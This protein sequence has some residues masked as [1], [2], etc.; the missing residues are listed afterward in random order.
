M[1]KNSTPDA[2][3]ADR[4]A[5]PD[6]P[7]PGA[8]ASADPGPVPHAD[9]ATPPRPGDDNTAPSLVW[10]PV[11]DELNGW[12]VVHFQSS[13][14]TVIE[15]MKFTPPA[16]PAASG[17]PTP[18]VPPYAPPAPIDD[19]AG[20]TTLLPLESDFDLPE[21][22]LIEP[23]S[24]QPPASAARV[25]DEDDARP[26]APDDRTVVIPRPAAFA[27]PHRP[28]PA[29]VPGVPESPRVSSQE[30]T[31]PG[32]ATRILVGPAFAASVGH[33]PTVPV[34]ALHRAERPQPAFGPRHPMEETLPAGVTREMLAR[35]SDGDTAT[36]HADDTVTRFIA[37]GD[38]HPSSVPAARRAPAGPAG[39]P[40]PFSRV[41]SRGPQP[42]VDG[43]AAPEP[44]PISLAPPPLAFGPRVPAPSAPAAAPPSIATAPTGPLSIAAAGLRDP[45]IPTRPAPTSTRSKLLSMAGALV[46]VLLLALGAYQV[47]SMRSTAAAGP[48]MA[49]LSVESSPAGATVVVD[50][51]PRGT[52]P[53]RLELAEGN[54]AL[55]VSHAGA[56]RRVPLTLAAGTITAHSFEFA[57]PPP[58]VVA[59]AAIEIRSEPAGGRVLVDGVP[60]GTTPIVVTG[61]TAGRHEVQVGGPF[62]TVT[63]TVTLAAKQQA[64]LV[65][66]PARPAATAEAGSARSPRAAAGTGFIAIESPIVLRVV[67]NGDFVGTS[68]DARLQL[69]VGPQVIGLENESV[70]FRDV[71]TVEVVAGKVTPVPVTLPKGE[72]SINARP[73]AEVFVDGSRI[74]ETPVSQL[75]LPVGIHEITFRHPEHGE[76]RVSVVVKIGATGRAFTDFT[77]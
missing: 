56:T 53:L 47:L 63:R 70:G 20:D 55:D 64:L 39:P 18:V 15:P 69:P 34:S 22:E 2:D 52:T 9:E 26:A 19:P 23:L 67:R 3:P 48:A 31:N 44:A 35:G 10:P 74:G 71:R 41:P 58:A 30:D 50:G 62:R 66:T 73:W 11:D 37:H 24:L 33:A 12:E 68:E 60:R 21:T 49:T 54:H 8:S 29:P 5:P 40:A 25:S 43:D 27:F 36:V 6:A 13:G 1:R 77:K 45:Q 14:E 65:V 61:L 28:A 4:T 59:D 75:S 7:A 32:V 76:R 51:T 46:V 16:A 17:E 42:V 38:T 57:A 72:I